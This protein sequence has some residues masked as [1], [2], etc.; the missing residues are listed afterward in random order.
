MPATLTYPGVYIEEIPSGVNPITGVATS[1][2]AFAGWAPEGP[3]DQAT[4]VQS[5]SDFQN[6]FGGLTQNNGKPNYL[7]YAVN[8][9]FS[10]GGQQAYIVR[11]VGPDAATAKLYIPADKISFSV[12]AIV[13]AAL[14]PDPT[15][16]GILITPVSPA[17]TTAFNFALCTLS[18]GTATV[19]GPTLNIQSLATFAATVSSASV[20]PTTTLGQY[21]TI[22]STPTVQPLPGLYVF[23]AEISGGV[24]SYSTEINAAPAPAFTV[25]PAALCPTGTYGVQLTPVSPPSAGVFNFA[26]FTVIGDTA[27]QIGPT[28]T[29]V[30]MATLQ[31]ALNAAAVTSTTTLGGNYVTITTGADQPALNPGPDELYTFEAG[32]NALSAIIPSLT[33]VAFQIQAIDPGQW[34]NDYGIRISASS[35]DADRFTLNVVSYNASGQET[36]VESFPNLSADADDSQNQFVESVVNDAGTGSSYIQIVSGST[37]GLPL[38]N[39]NLPAP[40]VSDPSYL[41]SGGADGAVLGPTDSAF[42]TALNAN[43]SV[44]NSD[45]RPIGVYLLAQ[46]S[47]F[48]LLCIPGLSDPATIQYLQ[49]FCYSQRAFYIVDSPQNQKLGPFISNGPGN[50]TG[51]YSINSALYFPWVI[52]PDPLNQNRTT[53]FPPCG[54]VAGIYAATDAARGVWKAPAGIDASLTGV[55][56]LATVLTDLENGSLNIQAIN[57]LRNFRVYGNV[58]WGARTLQGNDEQAS[59]WKYVPIRRLALYLESSLYDGTQWVVFEPNDEPLWS[60]IRLNVGAFLQGLFL[61]GAFQGSSPQQAYFVKCDSENN[62]QSSIDQGIVNILVGFA[63]LY[64]AEF[65]VI[66]IQQMA[67]QIQS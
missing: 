2:A 20:N 33:S 45:G 11:L 29:N 16:F 67:G 19:V 49:G 26:L 39:P 61:Q 56:G 8:Q 52:A 66:Q 15:S 10:N 64:P 58:V 4:L 47:I 53:T 31:T 50:I 38:P 13:S 24:T 42:L 23:N 36:V 22:P 37:S 48:N 17:S 32:A 59:Q 14:M 63:P 40:A 3:I 18:G 27:T 35:F 9:F 6:Q 46:V 54:F 43:G 34:A 65:V 12:D 1:I 30:T 51:N 44:T 25:G 21:I 62:P 60:Q 7:G 57:C 55:S 5:W 41:L 28:I